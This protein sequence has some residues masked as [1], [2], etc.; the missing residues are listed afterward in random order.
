MRRFG[1]IIKVQ[2]AHD[3]LLDQY[4]STIIKVCLRKIVFMCRL[5][6]AAKGKYLLKCSGTFELL[7]IFCVASRTKFI[8]KAHNIYTFLVLFHL[9][10]H[11][12]FRTDL[13]VELQNC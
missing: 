9:K 6:G 5:A 7:I 2:R 11:L 1:N 10:A 8:M 13:E 12:W 3:C 4:V